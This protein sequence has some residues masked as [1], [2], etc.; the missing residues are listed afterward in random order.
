MALNSSVPSTLT[1]LSNSLPHVSVCFP[2]TLSFV[3]PLE[4]KAASIAVSG[5][6]GPVTHSVARAVVAAELR[7]KTMSGADE[8]QHEWQQGAG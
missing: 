3:A 7:P 1:M 5:E 4:T 2:T 6:V 8:W